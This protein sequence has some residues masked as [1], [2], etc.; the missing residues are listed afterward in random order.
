MKRKKQTKVSLGTYTK[1]NRKF[2]KYAYFIFI[3]RAADFLVS[4][5]VFNIIQ[6]IMTE[7]CVN[8]GV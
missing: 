3:F 8:C 1:C 7:Y 2:M 4:L 5:R 6:Y